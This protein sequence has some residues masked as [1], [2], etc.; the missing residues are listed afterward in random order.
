MLADEPRAED[1]R[2]KDAIRAPPGA[3]E[4][5]ALILHYD[6]VAL[7]GRNRSWFEDVLVR[8]VRMAFRPPGWSGARP[9]VR[10]L[11]GRIRLDLPEGPEGADWKEVA[12]RLQRVFGIAYMVPVV[13]TQPTLESLAA[14]AVRALAGVH[15]PRTFG[16]HCKRADKEL[17][18]TSMDVQ[19]AVG[20]AVQAATG[21]KVQ[22]EEPDLP[23]R[24]E[25][26][27]QTAFVGVGRLEGPGGLPSG[28][29]RKVV[30]L[31]SGGIDSPV[32][33]YRILRRGASAVYV[34]FHSHPHT[35]IESQEKV[36]ELASRLQPPGRRARLY[37]LPFAGL[38]RRI[39][40]S[41]PS[42]L[43]VLL[44]RRFMVRAAE[45]IARRESAL[46]L[47]TGENLGQVASQTLENLRTIDAVAGLP[48]LR[49]LI[50]MDKAEIV[51]EARR[52]GTFEVSIEPHDDCCSFLMPPNPATCS[53]PA[54]LEEAEKVFDVEAETR[55]LVE[56]G[57]RVV[58][59]EGAEAAPLGA[60]PLP[61]QE[62]A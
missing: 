35:G 22:L 14:T 32:S 16:V 21:W 40:A 38:Q 1:S 60:G 46:A 15:G 25:V 43:R 29:A 4:P 39:V 20:A 48:V 58:V 10:R 51:E 13:S 12:A 2:T 5:K 57:T 24:I 52:I 62:G 53:Q 19:R 41:C 31:L 33:A 9:Q 56:S 34:H 30:C 3:F 61:S 37:L 45:L 44:Y 8:S 7:K 26:L 28:V 42:A 11:Y 18:F 50:G 27:S 36:R 49:P 55:A 17:P 47:V 23:V 59:G 6:E 54:E